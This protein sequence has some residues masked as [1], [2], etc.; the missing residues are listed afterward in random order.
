[1]VIVGDDAGEVLE[2]EIIAKWYGGNFR[3]PYCMKI[4]KKF[5][6]HWRSKIL[7]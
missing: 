4:R 3:P 6:D 7:E 5:Q 1:M 2:E